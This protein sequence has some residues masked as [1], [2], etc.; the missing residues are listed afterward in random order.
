MADRPV[1]G[2]PDTFGQRAMFGVTRS[3]GAKYLLSIYLAPRQRC[4]VLSPLG[5]R[6]V[7]V[8]IAVASVAAVA[9]TEM[10]GAPMATKVADD[11]RALVGGQEE[12]PN[13]LFVV[14]DT[15][16]ADHLST[17]GYNRDTSPFLSRLAKDSALF[18]NATAPAVTSLPAHASL[19]TGFF[20]S[21]TSAHEEHPV[22]N[23]PAPTL[24]EILSSAGYQTHAVTANPH[25]D[26]ALGLGRGFDSISEV[27]RQHP[28][29]FAS[30]ESDLSPSR[31]RGE[32][33]GGADVIRDAIDWLHNRNPAS[34]FLLFVNLLE[35]HFPYCQLP[36]GFLHRYTDKDNI[37]LANSNRSL[38]ASQFGGATNGQDQ[39]LSLIHI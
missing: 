19:F 12:R 25:I 7:A 33:H 23:S 27:W 31:P 6:L 16:R 10:H 1:G 15:V 9:L 2:P 13:V 3:S 20:P 38:F 24:A 28:D 30:S 5:R 35:A 32:D 11:R 26:R 37:T 29:T 14:L 39:E 34:P 17:Y 18:E 36:E 4:I 22:L 8:T 21:R